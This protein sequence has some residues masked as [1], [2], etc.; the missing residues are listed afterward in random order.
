MRSIYYLFPRFYVLIIFVLLEIFA[1][2]LVF[3]SH[4]Y[5]EVRFL[6]T[7]NA[8]AGKT[9]GLVNS[10]YTFINLGENNKALMEENVRLKAQIQYQNT[11]VV[12]S[13]LPKNSEQYSFEYIPAKIVNNSINKN[14]N[15]I[16]LNKG[17]KDGVQKG[18]GVI[19]SNGVVGV[20]T[21]V[22]ENFSLVM[23]V[24]SIKSLIGVRHKGTNALGN[25]RWNGEDPYTLQVDNL[26]KTL[27]IKKN[28]T[29]VTAG[30]SSL[31]PPDIVVAKVKKLKPEESTSFYEMDVQ[32]TNNINSLSYVYVVKNS[33]KKEIDDLES[34]AAN[35]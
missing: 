15:Y 22:S 7:S 13:S 17:S 28:D 26:S 4:K 30:F 10:F 3:K 1:L 25:L 19:S 27:P 12:D 24:I 18:L 2:T 16:T 6:N 34:Q 5:Q 31:F 33:K 11:Y 14:I 23:S 35:E 21:N 9:L 32:L 20:I 29:I 8:V